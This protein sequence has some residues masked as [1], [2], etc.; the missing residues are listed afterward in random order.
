MNAPTNSAETRR[1]AAATEGRF[2]GRNSSFGGLLRNRGW[3]RMDALAVVGLMTLAGCSSVQSI[4]PWQ[5]D[6]GATKT[7][8][9]QAAQPQL[10]VDNSDP[11]MRLLATLP[12][13]V[14]QGFREPATG[15]MLRVRVLSAYTAASGRPCREYLVVTPAGDEQ[16]R[17]ACAEGDRWVAARPLRLETA[18]SATTR[19]Q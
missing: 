19:T 5:S 11:L 6:A 3:R 14:D 9:S 8:R 4:N 10:K 17:V 13:T 18:A 12:M 1:H 16:R 15:E 2:A 7:A